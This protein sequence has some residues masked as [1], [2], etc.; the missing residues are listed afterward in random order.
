ML[1]RTIIDYLEDR[2]A[3]C[4]EKRAVSDRD[5]VLTWR[6]LK[7]EAEGVGHVLAE[8]LEKGSPVAIFA[9]K[10]VHV[11]SCMYGAVYAGGF[12]VSINP[13]QPAERIRRILDVLEPAAVIVDASLEDTLKATG[14]EGRVLPM[15]D[16]LERVSGGKYDSD[17]APIREA[18][19]RDDLLYAVFTS[20]STG[21]PKGVA[22]SQGAVIDFIGHFTEIFGIRGDDVLGGQAPFDFDVS[23]KD[24]YSSLMT[25]AEMVMIPRE[26][27]STVARLL[28][29]LIERRVSVVIWAVS[30][31]CIIS[32][33]KGFDYKVPDGLRLIMFS[34]EVMPI[35]HL[36]LWQRAVPGAEYVNLYGPSEITCNCTYYRIGERDENM[37]KIPIGIPFPGR[38][39]ILLDPDR[40]PVTEK[41]AT[42]EMCVAGE[43]L[44]AGY[45]HNPEQTQDRFI[46]YTFPDGSVKR[47]YRTGDACYLGEDGNYY[48]AGR[49]DFQIKHMGHRIE[50]EE[51]ETNLGLLE[52]LTRACCVF[53]EEKNRIVAFYTGTAEPRELR[54][55]LKEK[56][57]VY[58]VPNKFIRLESLPLNKNGKI[59]RARIRKEQGI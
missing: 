31:L 57:P 23:V 14:F 2:A 42:G 10:T 41:G 27:F 50:L 45:Y 19:G 54:R 40:K 47:T 8:F 58:M 17:L 51:I 30:A 20:G 5:S 52:G 24:I 56:V 39:I 4:P 53:Q 9:E 37:T 15:E 35:K 48:F 6:G 28:D 16:L 33:M 44:A 49:V 11:L 59:D 21:V 1:N 32:G 22:V 25:G 3:E 34:G 55:A 7:E 46:S 12:Y 26:Y 29:Y 38:E 43:S 13:E 18:M 36:R